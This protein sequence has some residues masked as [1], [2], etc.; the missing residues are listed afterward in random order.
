MKFYISQTLS[1]KKTQNESFMERGTQTLSFPP[2]SK[3]VQI[4]PPKTK[5]IECTATE[6]DIYDSF[7]TT[8]EDNR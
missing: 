1:R 4:A 5:E 6:W 2:K 7:N 8:K 3:E